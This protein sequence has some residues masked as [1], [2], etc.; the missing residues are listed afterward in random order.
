M[1]SATH[2]NIQLFEWKRGGDVFHGKGLWLTESSK[3]TTS[4][5]P[6]TPE[7]APFLTVVGSSNFGGRSLERDVESQVVVLTRNRDLMAKMQQ[8]RAQLFQHAR[9]MTSH[10]VAASPAHQLSFSSRML[11][12]AIG[13]I[14]SL[15]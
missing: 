15:F 6:D 13:L 7:P 12:R 4:V 14:K 2:P 1:T 3:S 8:E 9:A 10:T 5:V 11:S